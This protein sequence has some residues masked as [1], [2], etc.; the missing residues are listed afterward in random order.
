[1]KTYITSDELEWE[2]SKIKGFSSKQL[3]DIPTGGFKMIKVEPNSL[4]P[5]HQHPDKTEFIYVLEGNVQITN[6]DEC[7][8][9]AKNDFYALPHSTKHSINN[10]SD[11]ECI[12]LVGAIKN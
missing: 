7:I 5:L 9:G 10:I 11:K 1:M 4:Y 12:L 8:D 6:G 2:T 3:L